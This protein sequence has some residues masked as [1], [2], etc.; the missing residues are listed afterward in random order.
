M[1]KCTFPPQPPSVTILFWKLGPQI[2]VSLP[3]IHLPTVT[4]SPVKEYAC[5]ALLNWK[6]WF[7]ISN[8]NVAKWANYVKNTIQL[9]IK[10]IND[11]LPFDRSLPKTQK[12]TKIAVHPMKSSKKLGNSRSSTISNTKYSTLKDIL[13]NIK[14]NC[15]H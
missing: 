10:V 9:N 13:E 3:P 4:I 15:I 5:S 14:R 12:T 11:I 7:L 2:N 6:I 8:R 1:W